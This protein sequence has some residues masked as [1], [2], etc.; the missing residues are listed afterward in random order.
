M[1]I[2]N[3]LSGQKLFPFFIHIHELVDNLNLSPK[4]LRLIQEDHC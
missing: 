4:T 3:T 1:T 2:W